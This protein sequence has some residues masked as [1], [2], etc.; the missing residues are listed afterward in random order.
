[1]VL[2]DYLLHDEQQFVQKSADVPQKFQSQLKTREEYGRNKN[3]PVRIL[4]RWP[5]KLLGSQIYHSPYNTGRITKI[6]IKHRKNI[7]KS[8]IIH[9]KILVMKP[10]VRAV[11]ILQITATA[12]AGRFSRNPMKVLKSLKRLAAVQISG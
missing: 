1:M 6:S 5:R 7:N 9:S 8:A 2:E 12:N 11:N 4:V 3:A 10:V